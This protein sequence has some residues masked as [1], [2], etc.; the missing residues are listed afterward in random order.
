MARWDGALSNGMPSTATESLH[1]ALHRSQPAKADSPLA[2][3]LEPCELQ[4]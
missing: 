3:P 2:M 1:Q 4:R